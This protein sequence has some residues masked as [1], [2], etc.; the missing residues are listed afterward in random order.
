MLTSRVINFGKESEEIERL[1]VQSIYIYI[2]TFLIKRTSF[3][4]ITTNV[5]ENFTMI[6]AQDRIHIACLPNKQPCNTRDKAVL[7]PPYRFPIEEKGQ[8]GRY[9]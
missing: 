1:R 2:F 5:F 4:R 6:Y 7:P 9:K 3:Y 8:G